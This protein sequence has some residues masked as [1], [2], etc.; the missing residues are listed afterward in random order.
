MRVVNLLRG[1]FIFRDIVIW[2]VDNKVYS[3]RIRCQK[4]LIYHVT[5]RVYR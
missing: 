5:V 4:Y 1:L 2:E 3:L